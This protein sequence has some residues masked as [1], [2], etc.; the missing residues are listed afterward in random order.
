MNAAEVPALLPVEVNVTSAAAT[1]VVPTNADAVE[2]SLK[3]VP[4]KVTMLE[5]APGTMAVVALVAVMVGATVL[6]APRPKAPTSANDAPFPP[7]ATDGLE[8][9]MVQGP[10]A[11]PV[12]MSSVAV[13]AVPLVATGAGVAATVTPVQTETATVGPVWKPEPVIV[14]GSAVVPAPGTAT[15]EGLRL[16]TPIPVIVKI[17]AVVTVPPSGFVTV[18]VYV[19]GVAELPVTEFEELIFTLNDVAL[20]KVAV[21]CTP[22]VTFPA[23]NAPVADSV[24]ASVVPFTVLVRVTVAPVTKP[25]PVM[26][27]VVTGAVG[28]ESTAPPTLSELTVG[29]AS[30]VIAFARVAV[31][32]SSTTVRL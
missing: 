29:A 7:L 15:A 11:A 27:S 18:T 9:V 12:A 8:T 17:A 31:P 19:P 3:P 32:L 24:L 13:T 2:Y 21:P 14:T 6:A 10:P 20:T 23:V 5:A 25:V 28:V 22:V 30:T 1:A 4:V 16:L 26:T